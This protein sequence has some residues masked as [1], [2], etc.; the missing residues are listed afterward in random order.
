L[1]QSQKVRHFERAKYAL[2]IVAIYGAV[3]NLLTLMLTEFSWVQCQRDFSLRR[4]SLL[5]QDAA[6][7][8]EMTSFIFSP[9]NRNTN[10]KVC[11]ATE[12]E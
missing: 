8:F 3:R 10:V 6:G 1:K 4:K 11:D 12:A 7:S 9:L 5:F 2:Q